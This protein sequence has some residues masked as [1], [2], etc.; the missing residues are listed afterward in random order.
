MPVVRRPGARVTRTIK[1]GLVVTIKVMT[2]D[3]WKHFASI[4]HRER[5]LTGGEIL[6][7]ARKAIGVA[8]EAVEDLRIVD[9]NGR[10]EDFVLQKRGD[11]I[12]SEN[13]GHLMPWK[14]EILEEIQAVNVFDT[15]DLKNL[16]SP[17]LLPS[18][19]GEIRTA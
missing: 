4:L 17:S 2:F 15:D 13:F 6:D 9:D 3:E 19:D 1:G 7:R 11:E 5:I 16:P 18:G 8:L 14:E 12:P 10:E